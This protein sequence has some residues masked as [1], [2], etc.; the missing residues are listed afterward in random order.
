MRIVSGKHRSRRITA[1]Q[2]LPVRPTTDMAKEGVFN[3][4]S[5]A[6]YIED[7]KV[8]DLFSGTGNISY[9]FGSRGCENITAV[10]QHKGCVNFI[11]KTAKE[12]DLNINTYNMS[13]S[14]YIE[15]CKTSFDVVFADPPYSFTTEELTDIVSG[16]FTNNIL[17]EEGV[18]IVEHTKD[19][20]LSENEFFV[21]VKRYGGCM[22][23]F[24]ENKNKN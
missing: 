18:L 6:Y 9:E 13:V 23:S 11:D 15:R 19:L 8:L 14:K 5:N 22:F 3:V 24:F 7:I 20:D 21:K 16:I 4:L 12:L 17:S 1:P 10:D 2:S